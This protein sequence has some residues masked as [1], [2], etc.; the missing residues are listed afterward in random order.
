[1]LALW[2][3]M[4]VVVADEFRDGNVPAQQALL[5]VAQRGFAALPPRVE[6]RY[7]RGDSACDEEALLSWLR[8]EKRA[9]GPPGRIG[10]AVSGRMH[11]AWHQEIVAMAEAQWQP[12]SE[13]SAAI[14]ECAAVDYV[15]EESAQNQYREPLR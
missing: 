7:F 12:Y 8:N 9:D 13:D 4:N 2:A 5:P 6:E 14:K 11:P 15:P 1:V 3:E 10:F